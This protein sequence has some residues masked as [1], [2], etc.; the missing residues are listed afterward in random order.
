MTDADAHVRRQSQI[1]VTM[2]RNSTTM[3]YVWETRWCRDL[4]P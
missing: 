2:L 4:R 3:L 1:A